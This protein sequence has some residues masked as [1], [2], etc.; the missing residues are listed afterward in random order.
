[1]D[2][3]IKNGEEIYEKFCKPSPLYPD[4]VVMLPRAPQQ[5]YIDVYPDGDENFRNDKQRQADYESEV[6]V[7]RALERLK[8]DIIVLHSFEYT[9]HQYRLCNKNHVRKNCPKCKSP[10]N[11][12]G[13]CDFLV[14]CNNFFVVIEVKNIQN[15]DYDDSKLHTIK[16]ECMTEDGKLQLRDGLNKTLKKFLEQR[17]KIVNLIKNID[18]DMKVLEFTAYPN[19][20]KKLECL[21]HHP[22]KT[23]V[24]FKEDFKKFSDWWKENVVPNIGSK[25]EYVT[26]FNYVRDIL[27]AI[28]CTDR[29]DNEQR[30]CSLGWSIK[31]IHEKLRNGQ[32]VYRKNIPKSV[33]APSIFME[34]F[35]VE[36]LTKDQHDLFSS[37][38]KFLWINGPAGAGKTLIL[39]G[40]M[41][42]LV[43]NDEEN[44]IV[45]FT[46]CRSGEENNLYQ[47]ALKMSGIGY[48]EICLD[49]KDIASELLEK[50]AECKKNNQVTFVTLNNG[51]C[52]SI[53][54]FINILRSVHDCSC[55][56][57]IDDFQAID[58]LSINKAS[59]DGVLIGFMEALLILSSK[60]TGENYIIVACD[61]SQ[62]WVPIL[63]YNANGNFPPRLPP[64]KFHDGCPLP[65]SSIMEK[66]FMINLKSNM[67]NT[68][69]MSEILNVIRKSLL[70]IFPK[71]K[72]NLVVFARQC[73]LFCLLKS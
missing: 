59:Y 14:I 70:F 55:S 24:I 7:Y 53:S 49:E 50:V 56:L 60:M 42:E 11:R 41:I 40:R 8:E 15:Q 3:Y 6:L 71:T 67:R 13:E 73:C 62:A 38:K 12:H 39:A 46:F 69:N 63:Y 27:L 72:K 61:V 22:E 16:P 64:C 58:A 9:H 1:M 57:F 52:A 20:S 23:S 10:A 45:L 17:E 25:D 18:E 34:C 32:F 68:A 31:Q 43:R 30:R 35:G 2:K 19:L 26:K 54:W 37:K 47:K 36:N 44:K 4:R 5:T 28:W 29:D 51:Y 65:L 66:N 21:F 48:Q 33:P